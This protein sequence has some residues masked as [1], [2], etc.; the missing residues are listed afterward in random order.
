MSM[1]D[2]TIYVADPVLWKSLA[3]CMAWVVQLLGPLWSALAYVAGVPARAF[4]HLCMQTCHASFHLCWRIT[5]QTASDSHWRLCMGGCAG[6][7]M[8][9]LA[10]G[11]EP[12]EEVARH[13]WH[14]CQT[15]LFPNRRFATTRMLLV[16]VPWTVCQCELLMGCL[17]CHGALE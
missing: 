10:A 13:I 7:N 2:P 15:N 9:E 11:D 1:R 5:R 3:T 12:G 17:Y 14:M 16:D 6:T 8:D 4:Q